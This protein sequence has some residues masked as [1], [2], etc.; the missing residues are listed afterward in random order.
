MD[1]MNAGNACP[2]GYELV[3]LAEP[4]A[5]FQAGQHWA[6]P[7]VDHAAQLMRRLV[8]DDTW[9]AQISAR[10][11]DTIRTEFSAEAAGIRYHARLSALSPRAGQ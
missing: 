8:D 4:Y 2:V 1:F 6:E 3:P 5:G 10:G 11:R 7:D 9:R